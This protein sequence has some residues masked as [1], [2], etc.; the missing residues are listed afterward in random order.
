MKQEIRESVKQAITKLYPDAAVDFSVD[1]APENTGA[2]FAS[3]AALVLAKKIGQKPMEIAGEIS[4]AIGEIRK[5]GEI[6]IAAPGFINFRCSLKYWHTVLAGILKDGQKYGSSKIGKGKK[7]NL[8]SVSANP[9]GPLTVGHGRGAIIGLVLANVLK[10]QGY[11]VIRDYYYNDAGLQM[12][13]LGESVQFC[14][15]KKLDQFIEGREY[16]AR[17]YMGAYI[18]AIAQQFIN[19]KHPNDADD[20]TVEEYTSFAAEKLFS[21]IKKTLGDLGVSFDN[22][23]KESDQNID[24]ILKLLEKAGIVD[25]R[26]GAKWLKNRQGSEDKVLIRKTGEPTYRL[27]DIAYHLDKTKKYDKVVTVLGA[28]HISQ[29]PDISYAVEKLDGDAGKIHVIINQFVTLD[30]GK[31][32][33]TR[34]AEYVT[35]DELIEEVGADVTKFFFSMNSATSHMNFNIDLARDTSEKNPLYKVQYAY[36]RINSILKKQQIKS[37]K[38]K[39][40]L[41]NN[42]DELSL[43]RELAKFPE[44]E[45]EIT[46]NYNIH[47]I[48]HYLLSLAEKFHGF[49]EKVRVIGEDKHLT[50]ARLALV[51]GVQTVLANGLRIMGIEPTE[52]M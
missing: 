35:L 23:V 1:Y 9:T 21:L 17:T 44:L 7:I 5:I 10:S 13:R 37:Q 29:F 46:A 40:E 14:V 4:K 18:E 11:E 30:G 22:Y 3:N 2:D 31:K 41:L 28:D 43:I 52:K 12:K 48:P 20:I 24:K 47:Q 27:P 49:Y 33:S 42:P 34:K 6:G 45:Q 16:P 51:Q 39:L 38:P 26:E 50:S 8:E 36:A 32:M 25:D 19:E 15:R